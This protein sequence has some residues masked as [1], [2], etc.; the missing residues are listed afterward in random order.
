MMGR[1]FAQED[2]A[3]SATS[4]TAKIVPGPGALAALDAGD[5][6]VI[7][8]GAPSAG[9]IR[10]LRR[11]ARTSMAAVSPNEYLPIPDS[12]RAAE[13]FK[14]AAKRRQWS[15]GRTF[16]S[17]PIIRKRL[18]APQCFA[19]LGPAQKIGVLRRLKTRPA[20]VRRFIR[21]NTQ[22]NLLKQVRGPLPSAVSALNCYLQFSQPHAEGPFPVTE[23]RV[24]ERSSVFNDTATFAN[25]TQHVQKVCFF[26]GTPTAWYTPDVNHV[27]KGLKKCQD[28]SLMFPNYIRGRLL[29]QLIQAESINSEFGQACRVSFLF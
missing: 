14:A 8:G 6:E 21:G 11:L 18:N 17:R 20:Q 29:L 9:P 3:N 28:R 26:L 12:G 23:R 7:A 24:L 15:L 10:T 27:A 1:R 5:V 16:P 4:L 19:S 22:R 2:I 25:Y 13:V